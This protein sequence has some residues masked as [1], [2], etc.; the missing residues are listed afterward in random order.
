MYIMQRL[1]AGMLIYNY[2]AHEDESH[3]TNGLICYFMLI[4]GRSE[5]YEASPV[6]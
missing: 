1:Y 5:R 4:T 6:E 3:A 2:A